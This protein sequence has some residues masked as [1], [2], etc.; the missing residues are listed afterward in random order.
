MD[1]VKRDWLR[2]APY[3]ENVAA[4][5]ALNLFERIRAFA[6]ISAKAG[7]RRIPASK[8]SLSKYG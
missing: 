6:T 7:S 3:L 1:V 5:N 8:G 2:F 4:T